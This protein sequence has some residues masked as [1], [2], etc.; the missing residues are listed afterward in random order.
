MTDAAARVLCA[1]LGC[2]AVDAMAGT[3]SW[4]GR[5]EN[6]DPTGYRALNCFTPAIVSEWFDAQ[7]F[8]VDASGVYTIEMTALTGGDTDGFYALYEKRFDA[9][10]PLQNCIATDDDSGVDHAPLLN[11]ELQTG[12]TYILVTTQCCSG[13]GPG[14]EI[15]YTNTITGP[16]NAVLAGSLA[17]D[18]DGDGVVDPLTDGLLLMRWLFG[19]RG[20]ALVDGASS[21]N[22]ARASSELIEAYLGALDV[23]PGTFETQRVGGTGGDPY[24]R[25]CPPASA[26]AGLKLRQDVFP[27]GSIGQVEVGCA[28]VTPGP[29]GAA[30]LGAPTTY[31]PALGD[32]PGPNPDTLSCPAGMV[33]TG[34]HGS[35]K[36]ILGSTLVVENIA[37]QCSPVSGGAS[38]QVVGPAYGTTTTP[39]ASPCPIGMAMRGIQ[40]QAG[41]ALDSLQVICR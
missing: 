27:Q 38:M 13:F 31:L 17:A 40:G 24:Q 16:G 19:I 33:V 8:S 5:L 34:L 2:A 10:N 1:L 15:N 30:A 22:A 39:F 28:P 12:R 14:K 29:L 18:I 35:T 36:V 41:I 3:M 20:G 7:G 37:L 9:N 23:R 6:P 32:H 26:V 21:A 4:S 25:L 11:V